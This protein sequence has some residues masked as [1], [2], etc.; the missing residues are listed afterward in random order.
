MVIFGYAYA[1]WS[2]G[3]THVA[4]SEQKRTVNWLWE[5]SKVLDMTY[6]VQTTTQLKPQ[7]QQQQQQPSSN[8]AWGNVRG[9]LVFFLFES[10]RQKLLRTFAAD[11]PEAVK[12]VFVASAKQ[13]G[14]PQQL[15]QQLLPCL[16]HRLC[17][18]PSSAC[19]LNCRLIS[20]AARSVFNN[21]T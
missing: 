18:C 6:I 10:I 19:N 16:G 12:N 20:Q 21:R 15:H 17:L 5:S 2:N 3:W 8:F 4:H 9:S 7:Q 14:R 13:R 1:V 11:F